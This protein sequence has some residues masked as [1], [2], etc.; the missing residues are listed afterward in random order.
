MPRLLRLIP[1]SLFVFVLFSFSTPSVANESSIY[2]PKTLLDAR[3]LVKI[4]PLQSKNK[5][6]MFLSEQNNPNYDEN[7]STSGVKRKV[8]PLA[9]ARNQIHAYQTIGI[10]DY[11]LGNYRSSLNILEKSLSIS[12]SKHLL[13]PEIESKILRVSLLWKMT[14]DLRKVEQPLTKIEEKLNASHMKNDQKERL[15]YWLSLTHAKIYSD[16]GKNEQAE[17]SY[18]FAKDYAKTSGNYEDGL[19]ASLRLGK[20][21]LKAH[22]FNLALKELIESYWIAI[23]KDNAQYIARA[24]HLLA[25][26][27]LE[28]KIY[29]KAQEHLSQAASFYGHYEQSPMF[30]NVLQ[31]LADVY[32]IQGRYNLALVHYFNVLDLELAEKDISKIIDL[33]LKLT[34]TYLNLYNFTLAK[35]YLTRA[36]DLLE[37]ADIK[38]QKTRAT[39]LTA[40]LN[41]LQKHSKEAED[42]AKYAL[43][44]AQAIE[45]NDIQ[46]QAL[47]LLH[48]ITKSTDNTKDS[49]HYLEEY[50]RLAAVN[51]KEKDEQLSQSFLNQIT[52]IEQSLHYKDQVNEFTNLSTDYSKTK[53]LTLIL[54]I[55][56]TV[57]F[58]LFVMKSR[59]LGQKNKLIRELNKELYTHPRS[60]LK[61]LRML[62]RKLPDSLNRS[63]RSYDQWRFGQLI[64]EPLN[65]RLKF[66]LIDIPMLS[67]I[68]ITHG[69]KVGRIEEKSFGEHI[70]SLIP[71]SARLYHLS[72]RSFLYIEP[73]PEKRHQPEKL[74]EQFKQI[75]DSFE[76]EVAVNRV[77][78]ISIADYPFLPRAYTAINDEDLIDLLLLAS[79]IGNTLVRFEQQSQWVSF[80]A[81]PLA[82]AASFAQNDMRR[83][84]LNAIQ[85][86]LIKVH[87][88]GAEENLAT[89]LSEL[90]KHEQDE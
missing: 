34:E 24:N 74:F 44:Q 79:D 65:D 38:A 46:L 60:G 37:Y 12:Q 43:Q 89:I 23:G 59:R 61:N 72:D 84:S 17:K 63:T 64:N 13:V 51:L 29:D 73:N 70:A 4:T 54:G 71:N 86:G 62:T 5:A 48:L 90:P 76:T 1:L 20:H 40:K 45:N 11:I 27:Y 77:F 32:F 82:P 28:C 88:S 81:I 31:K 30:A 9:K 69:Y 22:H 15:E 18:L 10:A 52:S 53:T 80:T 49:L 26:L 3:R 75:I 83:S 85:K 57:L 16:L 19:E 66:S 68:Y 6:K 8:T 67:D 47:S 33:R 21:Y 2:I 36:S 87:T 50:N 78:S 35:R 56:C 25:D 55:S 42:Q 7:F 58:F 39:L 14:A 41:F